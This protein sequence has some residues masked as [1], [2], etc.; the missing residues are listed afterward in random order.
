MQM[1]YQ[2]ET[3]GPGTA[4]ESHGEYHLPDYAGDLKK[5]LCAS[6]RIVPAGKFFGDGEVQFGGAVQYDFWYLDAENKLTHEAFSSDYEFSCVRGEQ[7]D[8]AAAVSVAHFSLRPS[9]PRR[10]T[11]RATLQA[12]VHLREEAEYALESEIDTSL[13]QT[14]EKTVQIGRMLFSKPA[15]R[16]YA[17]AIALPASYAVGAEVSLCEG[18]V[19]IERA[20]A[21][22]GGVILHGTYAV[23][24]VLM[25]DGAAPLRVAEEFPIEE[26]IPLEGCAE[27]MNV[28]ASGF[29][30]SLTASVKE[31]ENGASLTFHGICE[32]SCT[33]E[34]NEAV[35]LIE[36]AFAVGGGA[37]AESETLAY[38]S[39]GFAKTVLRSVEL[40]LPLGEDATCASDG[41]FHTTVLLKNEARTARERELC[42]TAE[43][44]VCA[45]G[46]STDE[47]GGRHYTA[48]K[49]TAPFS[50]SVPLETEP[51]ADGKISVEASVGLCEGR[52]DDG[53]I[54]VRF[55]L[56]LCIR[57]RAEREMTCVRRV[58]VAANE[59]EKR[60]P[61]Y[62]I[63]YP[64]ARE[65]LWSIAKRYG[66]SV[67]S[68]A[69][70]NRISAPTAGSAGPLP[71][72]ILIDCRKNRR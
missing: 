9:G 40:Q 61:A 69:A 62:E 31:G 33:A 48:H 3:G 15:E 60:A 23:V 7:T 53:A 12:R 32:L 64:S 24:A 68:I 37:S 50:V 57:N 49:L 55:C 38:D 63:Y 56:M 17:E 35:S 52:M 11:A 51:L 36:D 14:S 4:F 41:I 30:T 26:R 2:K 45:L 66:V 19:Q 72:S 5:I 42:Y 70:A 20:E 27:A 34:G 22:E 44:E 47:E 29:F 10:I 39:F 1:K 25:A 13:L 54:C 28:T 67:A 21:E 8:G 71:S 18:Y 46:F 16:E 59:K 6:A 65:T 58:R 43:A